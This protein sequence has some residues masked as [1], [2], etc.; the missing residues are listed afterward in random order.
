MAGLS[1]LHY[2][3]HRNILRKKQNSRQLF[4]ISFS[5]IQREYFGFLSEKFRQSCQYCILR[6]HDKILKDFCWGKLIF[7][8]FFGN[9]AQN[10][11]ASGTISLAGLSKLHY[12]C[13]HYTCLKMILEKYF[14]SKN[15][16]LQLLQWTRFMQ[17]WPPFRKLSHKN[18]KV[19]LSISEND[20][21][22][23]F[24]FKLNFFLSNCSYRH[25]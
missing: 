6:I 1:K 17:L 9:W 8:I 22:Y 5:D 2:T 14:F 25:V 19:F 18:P 7:F 16:I 15:L 12:T 10:F 21:N 11:R 20:I 13:L 23:L 4:L 3:W 24:F